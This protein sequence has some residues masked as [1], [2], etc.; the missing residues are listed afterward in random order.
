MQRPLRVGVLEPYYGGSHAAFVDTVIQHSRHDC[1]LAQL[2]ARKWKWRM[3]GSAMW[4]ALH[5]IDWLQGGGV[6][7][8]D[9]ILCNDMLSVADLRSLLPSNLRNISIVCYFHENQLTYP[10]SDGDMRDYQ[11]GMT[12]ITSCLAADSVWFNS[13]A[14][15]Q[16]FLS[17]ADNLL[18]KM[19]DHV[20]AAI[21][22]RIEK[23][24]Q[25]VYP[26]VDVNH[27]E[28][29]DNLGHNQDPI[30]I[31]WCHRWEYDKNPKPFFDALRKADQ[32]SLPF[33][34]VA[35]GEQF[36][37]APPEFA[38]F[39][40]DVKHRVRHAGFVPA[41]NDYLTLVSSCDIVVSTANQENFGIAVVE[42]MMLGCQPLFPNRLSYPELLPS[43]F[44]DECLYQTDD[45][46]SKQLLSLIRGDAK[47][48][49]SQRQSLAEY[50]TNS[51]AAK[52]QVPRMDDQLQKVV[53]DKARSK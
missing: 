51:F 47:F 7:P 34:I 32:M 41:R 4:F 11:Y 17:A 26:A 49:T 14:H 12:N 2:P 1:V 28:K 44:R 13:Q 43:E 22:S 36:R 35:V 20:P 15:Q 5:E 21:V 46:F 9:V 25:V 39:F 53:L 50:L 31:L 3:R 27:K 24:S 6:A 10:L 23:K 8:V 33:D 18:R 48:S 45:D 16:S 37:T 42:A 30:T 40:N 29:G 52:S 19:P 38:K